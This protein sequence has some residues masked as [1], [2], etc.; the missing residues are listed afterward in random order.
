M[1]KKIILFGDSITGG[2]VNHEN[3]DILDRLAT[4]HL[5]N[6][7]F[8]GYEFINMGVNGE[9]SR[10]GLK[11][12]AEVAEQDSKFVVI[13]FGDNDAVDQHVSPQEY[14]ENLEKMIE[15]I[16]GAK[17]ILLSPGYIRVMD[18][19]VLEVYVAAAKNAAGDE[20]TFLNLYHHMTVYP[21]KNEFLQSDGLHLSELGYDLLS[22]LIARDIKIKLLAEQN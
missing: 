22:S 17:V 14:Q 1:T 3:T 11:R 16:G 18:Q 4:Q 10:D 7:G 12:A 6:M 15:K 19:T 5:S 13:F 2:Y 20:A 9:T 8:P 21:G